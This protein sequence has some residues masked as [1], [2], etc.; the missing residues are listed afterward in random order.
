MYYL[1]RKKNNLSS[2][3]YSI[4]IFLSAS[5]CAWTRV[6]LCM[7]VYVCVY[8]CVSVCV[9]VCVCICVVEKK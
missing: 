2:C 6:C 3:V 8:V 1:E 9:Y 5:K 4:H 7:C